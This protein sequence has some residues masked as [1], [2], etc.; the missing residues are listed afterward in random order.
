MRWPSE[1][2]WNTA[3]ARARP[4]HDRQRGSNPQFH[5]QMPRTR[6]NK[7][8]LS[9]TVVSP[10]FTPLCFWHVGDLRSVAIIKGQQEPVT[11]N[12][13]SQDIKYCPSNY[14]SVEAY[15]VCKRRR[16]QNA[17]IELLA[18][19]FACCLYWRFFI[20][21]MFFAYLSYLIVS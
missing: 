14:F 6:Q 21:F 17:K 18:F 4:P 2:P 13:L 20:L 19:V 15:F 5:A 9:K 7:R 8:F 10:F 3:V 12:T 11:E 16:C 1:N